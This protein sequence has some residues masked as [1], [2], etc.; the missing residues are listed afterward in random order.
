MTSTRLALAA[1]LSIIAAG[2]VFAGTTPAQRCAAAASGALAS[3]VQKVG[4]RVRKCYLDTGQPCASSDPRT[5]EELAKLDRAV[6]RKCPSAATVQAAGYGAL[7]TPAALADRLK[8]SCAG[9]PATLAARTF[10][11]PQAVLLAGADATRLQCL[12][13]AMLESVKLLRKT[14]ATQSACIRKARR[15]KTCNTTQTAAEVGAV[16]SRASALIGAACADLK[17]TLGMDLATYVGRAA[18]QARC[19]TATANGDGG[20]VTLD[21]GPRAAVP[22]PPRGQW[23]Q[24]VLDEATWGTRCGDG[25]SYAFWLKLAPAGSPPER[26]VVDLEGGGVCIFEADCAG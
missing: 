5:V 20:P 1:T 17:A 23:V 3:C 12:G 22:P 21:C 10:G 14:L 2:P 25:S 16:E 15:G 8:E 7:A 11:G 19:M 26:V 6:S 18:A 24:V 4:A 13:T 9:D